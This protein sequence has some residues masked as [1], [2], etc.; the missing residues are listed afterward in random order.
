[1][2]GIPRRRLRP[3]ATTVL[4][5]VA[6]A[7]AGCGGSSTSTTVRPGPSVRAPVTVQYAPGMTAEVFLPEGI[8]RAPLVVLVP[9][10]GWYTA[11]P[12]GL[13][14]LGAYLAVHG[15]I[16]APTHI[17]AAQDGVTYPTPVED[18]LC[19]VAAVT[20]QVRSQGFVT[21]HVAVLGH[22]S[23]AHLAALAVLAPDDYSPSCG[24]P[25]VRPDALIGLAGP[26]DVGAVPDLATVLL[27]SSPDDD[28]A[29]WAAAN[30]VERA[31]LRPEV[32][33]LL[34]HGTADE[35]V[36]VDLT[37]RFATA[38][39]AAGHPTTVRLLS[40]VDHEAVFGANVAGPPVVRWLAG[41]PAAAVRPPQHR[42][43]ARRR[44]RTG[45]QPAPQAWLRDSS[46]RTP[47]ARAGPRR[48]VSR[49]GHD[50]RRRRRGMPASGT[51]AGAIRAFTS[52][53]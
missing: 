48:T 40:G 39:D 8:K 35:I 16:A 29:A 21:N 41:L 34:L 9:G 36:P 3:V 30:P 33:V 1:M 31:A 18:V 23:G 12:S 24:S 6:S 13:T 37:S 44:R 43:G 45:R 2:D 7:A 47:S 28:P 25:R 46:A 15:V 10:G 32:P 26:Y 27:G 22:S 42:R 4:V 50:G 49:L 11:D 20:A 38:L 17:R 53:R 5:L 52:T 14:G 51:R 19:A